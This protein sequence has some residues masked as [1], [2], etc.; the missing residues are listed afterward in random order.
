MKEGKLVRQWNIL[1]ILQASKMGVTV[2]ELAQRVQHSPRGIYRDLNSL[3]HAGFAL[4]SQKSERQTRWKLV[5][6]ARTFSGTPVSLNE[7]MSLQ[8]SRDLMKVYSGSEYCEDL[9]RLFER[10]KKTL[11]EDSSAH[12][13]HF[14][15]AIQV[16]FT[17]FKRYDG[18]RELIDPLSKAITSQRRIQISYK[19]ASSKMEKTTIVD[20]YQ[21]WGVDTQLYLLGFCHLRMDA[22]TFAIDRIIETKLLDEEFQRPDENVVHEF[23]TKAFKVMLG[24]PE[25]VRIRFVSLVAHTV[26]ERRWH[27]SQEVRVLKNGSAIL[28][29][30][31][32]INYEIIAWILGY[33]SKATV[34]EP[35]SLRRRIKSEIRQTL[36]KYDSRMARAFKTEIASR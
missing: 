12:L 18:V 21:I 3:I 14:E 24:E 15:Q 1:Q 34:L 2:S 22:R 23:K 7:L 28:T 5:D 27:P 11:S 36:K 6:G 31:V 10:L 26:T 30:K 4:S 35:L 25:T 20:P 9:S 16:E 19:S 17:G 32:P 33:G 29:L 13:E 8:I